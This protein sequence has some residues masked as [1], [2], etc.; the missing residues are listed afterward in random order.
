ML[1]IP[2]VDIKQGKCVRLLQGRMEDSTHYS[3]DPVKMA[4]KWEAQGASLI[5]V[6]DLDGAFAKKVQNFKSIQDILTGINVPIQVGGGIRDLT[7][8]EM[9]LDVGVSKV[10]IGSEALYNP[11][12]VKDACRQFPGKIVVGIDARNGR[13]AVEGWSRTSDTRA[14]DLAKEFE[15]C[16]VAAIN[17]T[18]ILKDGMQIGPNIEETA[19]LA[20]AVSIPIVASGG[21]NTLQDIKNLVEI[22]SKGVIGVITGRALYE[23]TLDLKEAIRISK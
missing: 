8:I 23:G 15:S 21:V 9:Y 2:A 4:Q 7:T 10:I 14:I 3:D 18:D 22:E 19:A 6:V 1:I 20:C 17:F 16:G 5:H 13:V 12:L 11:G